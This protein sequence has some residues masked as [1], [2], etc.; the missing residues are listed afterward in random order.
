VNY[1]YTSTTATN[2]PVSV[3]EYYKKIDFDAELIA[4]KYTTEFM[5][6]KDY[7]GQC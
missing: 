6:S 2:T 1:Q 3:L 4:K 7:V 5:S